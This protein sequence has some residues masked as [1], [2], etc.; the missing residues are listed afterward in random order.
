[1]EDRV[2]EFKK[3]LRSPSELILRITPRTGSIIKITRIM[4]RLESRILNDDKNP[5]PTLQKNKLSVSI[6]I[7]C[8]AKILNPQKGK[9]MTRE[10]YCDAFKL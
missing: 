5:N 3:L 7:N 6:S 1:M 9:H 10:S 4:L 8:L 2:L